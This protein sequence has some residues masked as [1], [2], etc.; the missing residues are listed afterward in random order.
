[1]HQIDEER[2]CPREHEVSKFSL[3]YNFANDSKFAKFAKLKTREI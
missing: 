2:L 3:K 1:M